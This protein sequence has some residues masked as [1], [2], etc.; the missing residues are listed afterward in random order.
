M[1]ITWSE[2]WEDLQIFIYRYHSFSFIDLSLIGA[3]YK[4]QNQMDD[5]KSAD[6][7]SQTRIQSLVKEKDELLDL[8]MTRGKIIQVNIYTQVVTNRWKIIQVN[9]RRV[10]RL[11]KK[12]TGKDESR[13]KTCWKIKQERGKAIQVNIQVVT[14]RRKIIQ[15]NRRRVNRL[16]KKITGKDGSRGKTCRKINRNEGRPSR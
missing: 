13:G 15:V 16:Y 14:N 4:L 10:K 1:S 9:R 6:L 12:I 11:Y 5:K 2:Y 8:A 7:E 3:N